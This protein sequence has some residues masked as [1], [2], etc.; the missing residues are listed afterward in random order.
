MLWLEQIFIPDTKP[1]DEDQWRLLILDGHKSHSTE[2]F[3][4][5]CLENKI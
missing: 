4:T 2:E 1:A 3:M 5:R